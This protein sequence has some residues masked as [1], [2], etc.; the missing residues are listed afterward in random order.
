MNKKTIYLIGILIVSGC[1]IYFFNLHNSLFWDDEDW[2]LNNQAVHSLSWANV[3]FW[4]IHNT[5]AGIGL[6]SNYYRPFLFFTF[7]LNYIISGAKPLGYHLVSNLIHIANGVLLFFLLRRLFKRDNLSFLVALIFLIHP[8][9]TEAVSYVSGRGDL[10]VTMF[11]FVSLWL[12]I[13]SWEAKR[14]V[15]YYGFSVISLIFALLS[16]ETAIIFPLLALL[17][18]VLFGSSDRIG[19]SLKKGFLRTWPY[20]VVVFSYGILRLTVLNFLDT[21]NFYIQPNIYSEHLFVRLVTFLDILLTYGRLLLIPVGLHMERSNE[22]FTSI[23]Q[24]PAW[25][26]LISLIALIYLL[27][28][29]Y[30]ISRKDF[31]KASEFKVLA[32]GILW[33]FIGLGPVSG[34]TPINS[35]IYE[36]WLYLPMIGFWVIICFYLTKLF[37]HLKSKKLII[38]RLLLVAI[39]TCY[40]LFFGYQ[41]IKRNILWG[42]AEAFYKD[43]LKYEPDSGRIN[44]NLGNLYFNKGDNVNAENYYKVAIQTADT[45]PQSHFNYGSIL[46]AKKD[47]Y[48]AIQEYKRA[49]EID[50]NF[51][52]AYQNLV[53]LYAKNGDLANA[54]IYIEGLKRLLPENPR[55][56]YNAALL[57]MTSNNKNLAIQNLNEGLK[58]LYL[59]PESKPLF[60][61]IQKQIQRTK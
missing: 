42:N 19:T 49:I 31:A 30:I 57:Y 26:V 38:Y 14:K 25:L 59:D 47:I 6:K 18:Y 33:F 52:Y 24:W 58:Y 21:L 56:Y 35:L 29:F 50:P 44:N 3:K 13:N 16:R 60:D 28:K 5:L 40:L 1:A 23:F 39:V 45:F 54:I 34:I 41:A 22:V 9:Q 11:M 37:E 48:G 10:L 51:Y 61:N 36:H 15:L 8:I 27:Y 4:F 43:I 32:F 53:V 17:V 7:A 46:E 2:I 20:F 12:F 55:V